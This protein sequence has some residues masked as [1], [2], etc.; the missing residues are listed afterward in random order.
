MR[1]DLC[2]DQLQFCQMLHL[3]FLPDIL[4]KSAD[5]VCHLIDSLV[6]FLNLHNLCTYRKNIKISATDFLKEMT[7]FLFQKRNDTL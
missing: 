5:P 1:I 2:L 4:Q 3:L 7:S 6:Q